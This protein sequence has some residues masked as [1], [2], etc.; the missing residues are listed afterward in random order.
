MYELAWG[1]VGECKE[2]AATAKGTS[3]EVF[4]AEYTSTQPAY[5]SNQQD[6][7]KM[8]RKKSKASYR[9]CKR[10]WSTKVPSSSVCDG[11]YLRTFS[12]MLVR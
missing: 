5:A 1:E 10:K 9:I 4:V 11:K 6:V 7:K 3:Q 8:T 12:T 2:Q